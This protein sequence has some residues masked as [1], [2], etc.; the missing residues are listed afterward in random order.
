MERGPSA[1]GAPPMER[2]LSA[3]DRD[4]EW[5]RGA[6]PD[7]PAKSSPVS[8]IIPQTR[9][10]LE[11]KKRSEL[12]TET[13]TSP[14]ADSKASP[15]G[16]ARPIDTA[17]KLKEVEEKLAQQAA[18]KKERDE[19][20][21][22]E[23]RLAKEKEEKEK[24]AQTPTAPRNFDNFRR[25]SAAPSND[26]K[27]ATPSKSASGSVAGDKTPAAVEETASPVA[28]PQEEDG[29]STVVSQKR[30]RGASKA[31]LSS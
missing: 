24:G 25:G 11:L 22:E 3:A 18:A 30:G 19:K 5:R 8:P 7:P 31:Q 21:R 10:K 27:D 1:R 17:A 20:L 26:G 14:S 12:A 16:A 23:K 15:F 28:Q 2:A 13:V 9:P 6:R 29:W 4:N